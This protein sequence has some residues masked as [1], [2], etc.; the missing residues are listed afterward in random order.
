MAKQIII[1]SGGR[2]GEAAFYQKRL[3]GMLNFLVVC[4]DGGVRHLDKLNIKPDVI[5]GDMD[6]VS[7]VELEKRE[8]AGA[9]IKRYPREKDASDTQ[10]A[11]AYALSLKPDAMEIWGALGGRIDHA[12]ANVFLLDWADKKGATAKL[13]DE[14]CEVF[15]VKKEAVFHNAEGQTVSIFALD[16]KAAGVSLSGFQYHLDN[17]TLAADSSHGISNFIIDSPATITVQAGKLLVIHY[18]QQDIFPEAD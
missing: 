12:L 13:I 5:I 17:E 15:L 2:L 14:Y 8:E 3:A 16:E 18:W 7:R 11:L 1:I 9:Q 10:L 4:C 6:S